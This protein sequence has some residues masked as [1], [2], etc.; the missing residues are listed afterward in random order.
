M[1]MICPYAGETQSV[2][3]RIAEGLLPAPNP[4]REG[5]EKDIMLDVSTLHLVR[6]V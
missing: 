2:E 5:M 3:F 6:P 4:P 1:M